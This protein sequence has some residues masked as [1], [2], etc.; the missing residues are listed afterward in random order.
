MAIQIEHRTGD[1]LWLLL[2]NLDSS[3]TSTFGKHMYR[4]CIRRVYYLFFAGTNI[5]PGVLIIT[6]TAAATLRQPIGRH[7][8]LLRRP[9]SRPHRRAVQHKG[10]PA[11]LVFFAHHLHR[12]LLVL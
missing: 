10:V 8:E 12:R 11:A 5:S 1:K 7:R 9:K 6:T 4:H 2:H 3:V